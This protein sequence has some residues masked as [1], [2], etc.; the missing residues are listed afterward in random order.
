MF[1]WKK[2][3]YHDFIKYYHPS[4]IYC[5]LCTRDR[6][7][8]EL[9]KE[10]E[11]LKMSLTN[12]V[13]HDEETM[14]E[15]KQLDKHIGIYEDAMCELEEFCDRMFVDKERCEDCLGGC[16]ECDNFKGR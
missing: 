14:E 3:G 1:K 11:E 9:K 2:C 10:N 5:P 15:N 12:A 8:V 6:V 16:T 4:A 7:I 13:A